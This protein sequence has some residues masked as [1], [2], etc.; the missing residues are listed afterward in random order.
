MECRTTKILASILDQK[1]NRAKKRKLE[2][3]DEMAML[4][5]AVKL[6]TERELELEKEFEERNQ[7]RLS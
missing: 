4:E 6:L 7:V 2:E 5:D 1:R 3:E